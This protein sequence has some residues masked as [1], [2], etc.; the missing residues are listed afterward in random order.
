MRRMASIWLVILLAAA[1]GVGVAQEPPQLMTPT[2]EAVP[3]DGLLADRGTAAVVVW[4]SWAPRAP[5]VL[6]ELEKMSE[7]CRQRGLQ[8]VLVDV[9]ETLDEASEHLRGRKVTWFHDRYGSVLK[10]FRVISV[11][12]LIIVDRD[13]GVIG[14][15]DSAT[16]AAIVAWRPQ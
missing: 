2:G 12:A 9:Q 6:A 11:P 13:G 7:A 8:L 14:R 3:L 10:H 16:A 5:E 4:A 15:P 1:T